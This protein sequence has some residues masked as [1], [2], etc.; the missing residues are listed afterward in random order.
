MAV[1]QQKRGKDATTP[2]PEAAA[3]PYYRALVG[4]LG[5]GVIAFAL[6][7]LFGRGT[8]EV[9][10]NRLLVQIGWILIACVLA[11][12]PTWYAARHR[13]WSE[14]WKLF[15]L[16]APAFWVLRAVT[17]IVDTLIFR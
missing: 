2:A 1:A 12:W 14:L 8:G 7:V 11:A 6:L 3:V 5:W 17:L 13:G 15:L 9:D 16:A 4:A 10:S